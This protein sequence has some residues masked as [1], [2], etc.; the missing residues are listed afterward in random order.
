M[1]E[2][3]SPY[4]AVHH[5]D[6]LDE[7][8]RGIQPNPA[9][10]Q[11]VLT[12]RCNHNCRLCAYRSQSY[13]SSQLFNPKD[14]IPYDKAIEILDS[15]T[16]LGVR[17]IQFTGG[18]EP[19]C[20]PQVDDVF[21]YVAESRMEFSLVTNGTLMS[22]KMK[23]ILPL[24][25]WVRVSIDAA[26]SKTYSQY[27]HAPEE[28]FKVACDNIAILAK[29]KEN[30]VLGVGFVVTKFNYHE[31]YQAVRLARDLGA[32]N[33]RISAAFQAERLD[34]FK[35]FFEEAR[36]QASRAVEDFSSKDF[37]VFNL[38]N[39]RINDMF[40]G[41]QSYGYC[42]I[43][44]LQT[45]IG[46]DL[47]VYVCCMWGYNRQG[48]IGSLKDQ[49]FHRLW[50]S[51]EKQQWFKG[52]NPIRDCPVPCMYQGKNE[53]MNYCLKENPRHVNFI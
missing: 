53:F 44:E 36:D 37:T 45:Y 22:D 18:G 25:S 30:G 41:R 47:G 39:D 48:L 9:H 23:E 3:Y 34:H 4:K 15:F 50:K 42:P 32:D 2:E 20:H 28:H 26:T 13:N 16:A 24:A 5:Q 49:T 7:M 31:I 19:L 8:R 40:V 29:K 17:A 6:K 46:A 14:E 1:K 38:F 11:L 43:K 27:R 10:V 51:K 52:H 33:L 12:N 21:E 35:S